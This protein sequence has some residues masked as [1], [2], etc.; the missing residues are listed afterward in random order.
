MCLGKVNNMRSVSVSWSSRYVTVVLDQGRT[1]VGLPHVSLGYRD[2][3]TLQPTHSAV[4]YPS[5]VNTGYECGSLIR[6]MC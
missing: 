3:N 4:L 5:C 2:V 1:N 6:L